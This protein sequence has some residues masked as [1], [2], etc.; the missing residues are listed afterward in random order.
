MSIGKGIKHSAQVPVI[1]FFAANPDEELSARDA[2][3]KFGFDDRRTAYD[4]F[5]CLSR[6]GYLS[7]TLKTHPRLWRAGPKLL[8]LIGKEE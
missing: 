6:D 4:A 1:A 7:P 5:K 8:Q 2:M 3:A